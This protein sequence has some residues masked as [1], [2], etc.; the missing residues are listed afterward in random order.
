M[1]AG[2]VVWDALHGARPVADF[3][4]ANG[5]DKSGWHDLEASGVS[6]DARTLAGTGTNPQGQP[7]AWRAHLPDTADLPPVP[8]HPEIVFDGDCDGEFGDHWPYALALATDGTLAVM[9]QDLSRG[10]DPPVGHMFRIHPDSRVDLCE[11]PLLGGVYPGLARSF[12][13]ATQ[14]KQVLRVDADGSVS[15]VLDVS[16]LPETGLPGD[17][18]APAIFDLSVAE[19]GT[20]YVAALNFALRLSPGGALRVVDAR[21][22]APLQIQYDPYPYIMSVQATRS[23]TG[24]FGTNS[25]IGTIFEIGAAA[26]PRRIPTDDSYTPSV[27]GLASSPGGDVWSWSWDYTAS[28]RLVMAS[29]IEQVAET[30]WNPAQTSAIFGFRQLQVARDGSLVL[31]D[32]ESDGIYRIASPIMLEAVTTAIIEPGPR[33]EQVGRRFALASDSVYAILGNRVVRV[34]V[35]FGTPQCS[36]GIDN[37]GDG[38]IDFPA[39]PGCTSAADESEHQATI[40]CDNGFDDDRDGLLD[41]KDPGCITPKS[42]KENPQ[43]SDGIDNDGD[44]KID[45]DGAGG[46]PDPDCAGKPWRDREGLACGLGYELSLLALLAPWIRSRRSAARTRTRR[47]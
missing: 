18:Y 20:L 37:D 16:T 38:A 14:D 28:L 11:V 31:F 23:G 44:G 12:Y 32:E 43:C 4:A 41:W 13:V 26:P 6:E 39:D 10:F 24:L 42:P 34:P 8:P 29:S 45:F 2:P 35:A 46:A 15:T 27:N 47:L 5:L 3:L 17:Q 40:G 25:P 36:D 19:D 33:P 21:D 1:A 7:E 22:L 30:I 9:T